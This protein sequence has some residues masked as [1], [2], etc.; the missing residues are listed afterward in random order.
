MDT[1]T[2][3]LTYVQC[4]IHID[5]FFK[6]KQLIYCFYNTSNR[7]AIKIV[8]HKQKDDKKILEKLAVDSSDLIWRYKKK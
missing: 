6:G 4:Y 2:I 8:A 7:Q 3:G 1:K 5:I